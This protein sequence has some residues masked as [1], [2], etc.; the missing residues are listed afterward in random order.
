MAE[1][2]EG[3][4]NDDQQNMSVVHSSVATMQQPS[5]SLG[6]DSSCALQVA[7]LLVYL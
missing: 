3:I 7:P 4:K 1:I 6:V 2:R 5:C